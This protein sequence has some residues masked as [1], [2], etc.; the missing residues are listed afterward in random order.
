[1]RYQAGP[2]HIIMPRIFAARFVCPSDFVFEDGVEVQIDNV[3]GPFGPVRFSFRTCR[4]RDGNISL[5]FSVEAEGLNLDEPTA[6]QSFADLGR[7]FPQIFAIASNAPGHDLRL[8]EEFVSCDAKRERRVLDSETA[9][10]VLQSFYECSARTWVFR[11]VREYEMAL[12]CHSQTQ[13]TIRLAHLYQA[14][15]AL[16]QAV[17][18]R[19]C[20]VHNCG[21]SELPKSLDLQPD[22]LEGYV[23]R[24]II[25][26]GDTDLFQVAYDANAR[27]FCLQHPEDVVLWDQNPVLLQSSQLVA[28]I[29]RHVLFDLADIPEHL[30]GRLNSRSYATPFSLA[31]ANGAP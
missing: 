22:E 26:N 3:P 15:A 29:V 20:R 16:S 8:P 19:L 14:S 18:R 6:I 25:F 28:A 5:P 10:I 13:S 11:A 1:M 7:T 4:S 21:I 31:G 24:Q 23:Y 12:R 27:L 17:I 30:L 9:V 2:S